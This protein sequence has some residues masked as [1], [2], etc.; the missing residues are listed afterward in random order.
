MCF[1]VFLDAQM[2][3]YVRNGKDFYTV[4]LEYMCK[5]I[6]G[7]IPDTYVLF[8]YIIYNYTFT[9]VRASEY[10]KITPH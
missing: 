6:F 4:P 2:A 8:V 5:F 9:C 10:D 7:D 3:K 1:P